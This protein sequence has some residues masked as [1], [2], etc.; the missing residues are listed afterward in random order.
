MTPERAMPRAGTLAAIA[1]L[2]ATDPMPLA[3]V[4]LAAGALFHTIDDAGG[5]I[6][7][8][9]LGNLGQLGDGTTRLADVPGV[10]RAEA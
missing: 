6:Y 7:S 3:D 10:R 5:T 9:G 8:C 1:L 4:T 2:G